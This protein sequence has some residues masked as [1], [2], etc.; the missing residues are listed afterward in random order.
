MKHLIGFRIEAK[1]RNEI[2]NIVIRRRI[3]PESHSEF[4]RPAVVNA[5]IPR[6]QA[7]DIIAPDTVEEEIPHYQTEYG[8]HPEKNRPVVFL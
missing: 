4:L 3:I 8:D 5:G 7:T 2:Q 6:F 1:E